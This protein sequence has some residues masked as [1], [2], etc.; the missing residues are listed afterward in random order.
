MQI[1][2]R[3]HGGPISAV[4]KGG[5]GPF[6]FRNNKYRGIAHRNVFSF[7]LTTPHLSTH[8]FT[9]RH[10]ALSEAWGYH[11][12]RD[13]KAAGKGWLIHRFYDSINKWLRRSFTVM[14]NKV[15]KSAVNT[16]SSVSKVAQ[17]ELKSS[18]IVTK[19]R[20]VK[21]WYSGVM[22]EILLLPAIS[23][24]SRYLRRIRIADW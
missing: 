6:G 10:L 18:D 20:P 21:I 19:V 2:S 15:S 14:Q 7:L 5:V 4:P 3:I 11:R 24:L 23:Y 22:P 1:N 8:F 9:P 12:R 16:P 13:Q 17:S